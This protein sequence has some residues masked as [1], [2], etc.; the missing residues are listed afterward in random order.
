M[1]DVTRAPLGPAGL[2]RRGFVA[3]SLA[4]AVAA[5]PGG[6]AGAATTTV[7]VGGLSF[8]LPPGVL[9]VPATQV[10]GGASWQWAG[11]R[12]AD[13]DRTGVLV[14]LA[15]ADLASSDPEEVAAWLLAGGVAGALP[16][17]AVEARRSRAMPGGGD[18]DRLDLG[19][20]AD[21]RTRWSGTVMVATRPEGRAGALAVL[22][23]DRLTAGE[24]SLV[25]DSARW[26]G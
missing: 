22:G 5:L 14:V 23:D 25:L 26:V 18:Q 1:P 9:E 8:A 19:Y 4:A 24:I 11:R 15:R 2:T 20:A 6:S 21:A 16:G 3:L 10:V 17:L 12:A 13:A 7:T